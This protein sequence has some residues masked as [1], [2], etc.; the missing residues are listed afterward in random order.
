VSASVTTKPAAGYWVQPETV[1]EA[2][3]SGPPFELG[4]LASKSLLI[5]LRVADII[6]QESLHVSIWGSEDGKNW[7]RKP[8]F[9]FPEKFYCG[10]TPASL[11]LR[12]RPEIRFLQA[13]WEVNRWGRGYPM[14]YFK[15]AVE[16]QQ[17]APA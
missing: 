13:R 10:A 15:F 3:G 17:L 14:P 5:V 4:Q 11:D 9:W 1:V 2:P 8:L 16:M 12:Q 7:G 6:E